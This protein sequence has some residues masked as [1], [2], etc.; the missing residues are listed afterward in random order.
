[1]G[2]Q[3][4]TRRAGVPGAIKVK[5]IFASHPDHL[6]GYGVKIR[7]APSRARPGVL[8]SA[9]PGNA[10]LRADKSLSLDL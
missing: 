3:V 1:M 5:P 2:G 8:A 10:S 9:S 4:L 7:R 6:Y